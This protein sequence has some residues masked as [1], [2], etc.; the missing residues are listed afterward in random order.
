MPQGSRCGVE[1]EA[2]CRFWL[3]EVVDLFGSY[4]RGEQCEAVI[5]RVSSS[6][7]REVSLLHCIGL[8]LFL[9]DT[10][11]LALEDAS[12]RSGRAELRDV[13]FAEAVMVWQM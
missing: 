4:V 8:E 1:S 6:S 11:G 12:C 3:V 9:A 13:T 10:L 7:D 2:S 5:L